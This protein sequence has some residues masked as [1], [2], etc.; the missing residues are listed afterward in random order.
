[1]QQ[2]RG[3]AQ[4]RNGFNVT[5]APGRL[6][7]PLR[8]S[9]SR[10][11]FVNS[12]SDLFHDLVPNDF[13]KKVFSIMAKANGHIYQVLTKRIDRVMQIQDQIAWSKNVWLGVSVENSREAWRI[14]FLRE[15]K[16]V[17]KFVSFEP[18]LEDISE[19]DLHGIDW[20][21]VG[22]EYGG[23]ARILRDEWVIKIMNYC[24]G[25]GIPFFFKQWGSKRSNPDKND[26]TL[27]RASTNFSKGGCSIGGK[28]VREFPT[29]IQ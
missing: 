13:I 1:M 23:N 16:A 4:Y 24:S 5:L 15:T 12:M 25:L 9:N 19:L 28:I 8:W 7:D 20:A 26:P 3:V 6:N 2:K 21:I 10:L 18:L 14:K 17:V 11:V 29:I 22:G 27:N